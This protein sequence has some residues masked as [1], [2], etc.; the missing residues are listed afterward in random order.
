MNS[1]SR[2]SICSAGVIAGAGAGILT[3]ALAG[4]IAGTSKFAGGGI[5]VLSAIGIVKEDCFIKTASL[6]VLGAVFLGGFYGQTLGAVYSAALGAPLGAILGV[7]T[8][9]KLGRGHASLQAEAEAGA[10]ELV[11]GPALVQAGELIDAAR[12]SRM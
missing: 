2:T 11:Q 4:V 12:R 3:G 5:G 6:G 7:I 10:V 8:S 9:A 1:I